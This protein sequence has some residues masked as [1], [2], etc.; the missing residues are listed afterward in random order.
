MVLYGLT[1]F[2]GAFLLFLV[3]PL[4]GKYLLPWF[5]G[6]PGVWTACLLFFQVMLLGGYAYAHLLTT[7][8]R[9]RRQA[10]VHLTFLGLA[11]CFLPVIPHPDLAP[12]TDAMPIL[13]ILGVLAAT[14]GVPYLVLSAT[15]PLLQRW[16]APER[17]GTA[18]WRLYALSNAG[19]LLALAAY[20]SVVDPLWSRPAQAWVWSGGLAV[21]ALLCG[22]CAW[23]VWRADRAPTAAERVPAPD[24]SPATGSRSTGSPPATGGAVAAWIALPSLA[25]L[26]LAAVTGKLTVDVAPVPFLWVLPLALYL[27]SFI[28]CFDHPRWYVRPVFVGALAISCCAVGYVLFGGRAVPLGMQLGIYPAV[29]FIACMV[30]HGEVYRLRPAAAQLT[31]F[32]LCLA[33]GSALGSLFVAVL[34]PLLFSG[35]YELQI[36]LCAL[37]VALGLLS[38]RERDRR[39]PLA[40]AAGTAL[41]LPVLPMLPAIVAQHAGPLTVYGH[42][43]VSMARKTGWIAG[44]GLALFAVCCHKRWRRG[45]PAFVLVSAAALAM[46]FFRLAQLGRDHVVVASR[47]FYGA[48][49]V[50]DLRADQPELRYLELKHGVTTHGTQFTATDRAAQP[51]TYYDH[52]SGV[53]FALDRLKSLT[54]RRVG[55]VGLGAGTLAAYGRAG[56]QFT[57]YEI[58]PAVIRLAHAPFTFLKNSA[59][60]IEIVAGDARLALAAEL[61]RGAPRQFDLLALDAFSSD[62]IPVHL[63]TAEAMEI[64]LA[65]LKPDGVLALHLSNRFLDLRSVAVGLARQFGLDFVVIDDAPAPEAYWAISSRWCLLTRDKHLLAK[66]LPSDPAARQQLEASYHPVLWTDDHASLFTIMLPR[67]TGGLGKPNN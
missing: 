12:A 65:Q 55:V 8:L 20:P 1:I 22:G 19:S 9:P 63:L 52:S 43:L 11:L 3:Q 54:G 25:S 62:A 7:H 32:Y 58:D 29:L 18:P 35:Y 56:D 40:L 24:P 6:G 48:L 10:L 26:L 13:R 33:A 31:R 67:S 42:E 47:N 44:A 66:W 16:L 51:T 5:G 36:G 41:A 37:L 61:Q 14:V 27:A 53:G 45:M 17:A 30:C 15:G 34:A 60:Q 23:Q 38:W 28:L 49:T 57:F 39:V 59:A 64:Y 46:G 2:T 21:F 50:S 4:M